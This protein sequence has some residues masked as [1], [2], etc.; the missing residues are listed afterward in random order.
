MDPRATQILDMLEPYL[1]GDYMIILNNMVVEKIDTTNGLIHIVPILCHFVNGDMTF[2]IT[3]SMEATVHA[4]ENATEGQTLKFEDILNS[5]IRIF[6]IKEQ[7]KIE[8]VWM[9]Q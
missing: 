7:V 9:Y 2:N 6:P 1:T 4:V 3:E 5:T 8:P